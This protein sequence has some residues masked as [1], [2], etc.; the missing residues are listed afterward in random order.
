MMRFRTTAVLLLS[1]F[2]IT[3][4][5][6]AQ[7][8][9]RV[10]GRVLDQTGAVLPGVV[11]DLLVNSRELTTTSDDGGHYRF[12]D[13]PP[14]N[15][16]LTLRLLN[17]S[18]LRRTVA[19][20]TGASVTA[21]V[22]VTLSLS[23]EVIVTGTST[24]RNVADVKDP[25]ANVVGIAAAASQG[26]VTAAQLDAR[27]VMRAGEVPW[28]QPDD[29]RKVNGV[30]RFS[31]GDNRNGFSLT[32]MGYWADW[33]ATDQVP[34]RAI[35][36]GLPRFGC[37]RPSTSSTLKSP[38]SITSTRLVCLVNLRVAWKTS[39]SIPRYRDLLVSVFSSPSD[40]WVLRQLLK[41]ATL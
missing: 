30:L 7:S 21:D 6:N 12:D 22:V 27:P 24:F 14:G 25:A 20:A 11:I 37:S 28:I 16:E 5:A 33:H 31:R 8:T 4:D 15:A 39:I 9:G 1:L 10:S 17:F 26:A 23:S 3:L 13:V 19:V 38:T 35:A 34:E 41:H 32:G 29:Y 18:V 2:G 36:G 40:P